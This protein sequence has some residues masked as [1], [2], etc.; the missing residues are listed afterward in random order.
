MSKKPPP[1]VDP[2][3]GSGVTEGAALLQRDVMAALEGLAEDDEREE[4][5]LVERPHPDTLPAPPQQVAVELVDFGRLEAIRGRWG[6]S[7]EARHGL[8]LGT[9][10]FVI[11]AV[12]EALAA[13][14]DANVQLHQGGA[15]RN[16]YY[17]IAVTFPGTDG[18]QRPVIRSAQRKGMAAI[19]GELARFARQAADGSIPAE[20][21]TG[22]VI[23]VHDRAATGLLWSSPPLEP[24]QCL[25]L[26]VHAAR[27]Q[28]VA[29]EAEP[30]AAARVTVRPVAHLVLAWDPRAMSV[31]T[32][33]QLLSRIKA[34]LEQP[35]RLLVEA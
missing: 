33:A 10:S 3:I 22:A 25:A 19:A 27:Q 9:S 17:D 18:A 20:D 14:P 15:L 30:G 29:L 4:D 24:P 7:F 6:S 2:T 35:E 34:C 32:A 1:A 5:G 13:V 16:N 12:V 8:V 28:A 31:E 23:T 21:Q 11:K 26:A